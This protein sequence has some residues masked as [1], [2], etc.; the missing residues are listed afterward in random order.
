V[1]PD[2]RRWPGSDLQFFVVHDVDTNRVGQRDNVAAN[3][4]VGRPPAGL[5]ILAGLELQ[6]LAGMPESVVVSTSD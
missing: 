4:I 1:L 2:V 5:A 3:E 6:E